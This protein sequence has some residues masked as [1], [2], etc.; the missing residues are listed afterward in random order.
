VTGFFEHNYIVL[1]LV[2]VPVIGKNEDANK[3]EDDYDCK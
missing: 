2:V 1:V 3:E